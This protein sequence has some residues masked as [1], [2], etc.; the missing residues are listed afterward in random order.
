MIK[1]QGKEQ[2]FAGSFVA[3]ADEEVFVDVPA[4]AGPVLRLSFKFLYGEGVN[5]VP[6]MAWDTKDGITRFTLIGF[7]RGLQG[8]GSSQLAQIGT[9]GN[10]GLFLQITYGMAGGDSRLVNIFLYTGGL[11][12]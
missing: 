6:T 11:D 7:A 3:D 2:I 8:L 10:G 1:K 5:P 9:A 12:A 4:L